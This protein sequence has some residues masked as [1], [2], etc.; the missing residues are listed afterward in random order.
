MRARTR[1]CVPCVAGSP[2][3]GALRVAVA[4]QCSGT[5]WHVRQSDK[6]DGLSRTMTSTRDHVDPAQEGTHPTWCSLDNSLCSGS[7]S[8]VVQTTAQ[9]MSSTITASV[10]HS[11]CAW[12]HAPAT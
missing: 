7:Q 10:H 12:R 11:S 4:Q 1:S 5:P 3:V 9:G 6:A 8:Y 2:A